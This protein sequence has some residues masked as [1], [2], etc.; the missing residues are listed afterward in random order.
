MIAL[1][2]VMENCVE[3]AWVKE[4]T[5]KHVRAVTTGNGSANAN[6]LIGNWSGEWQ[7]LNAG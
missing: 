4:R 2:V 3:I 7:L 6:C 5:D 1:Q